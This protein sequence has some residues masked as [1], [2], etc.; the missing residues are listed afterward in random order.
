VRVRFAGPRVPSNPGRLA[1]R[2]FCPDRRGLLARCSTKPFSAADEAGLKQESALMALDQTTGCDH[3]GH[4]HHL[5][6]PPLLP[7]EF[8]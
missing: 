3:V 8:G 1:A 5:I 7:V 2:R 4:H 6:L